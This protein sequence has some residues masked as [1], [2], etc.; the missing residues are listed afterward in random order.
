MIAT[1]AFIDEYGNPNLEVVEVK[2]SYLPYFHPQHYL[3]AG[4]MPFG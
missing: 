3:D 1:W 4:P 2:W